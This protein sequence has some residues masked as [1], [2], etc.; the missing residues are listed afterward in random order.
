MT[1]SQTMSRAP[2][3]CLALVA[4]AAFCALMALRLRRTPDF[5]WWIRGCALMLAV[6]AIVARGVAGTASAQ[7]W[8]EP[9][10]GAVF[11]VK[12]DDMTL[13]GGGLRVKKMVFT[14]KAY[15]IGFYV[16]DAALAGPLAAYKTASPELFK[17]LQTGDFPKAVAALR[18]AGH[19][20]EE[21]PNQRRAD[22]TE[23]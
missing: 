8:T 9:K 17:Q 6:A 13:L 16:S 10:S 4:V 2:I 22:A 20:V 19:E 18:G 14:F 21:R 12:K 3:A 23:P 11:A 15:A 7:T 1:L 5:G